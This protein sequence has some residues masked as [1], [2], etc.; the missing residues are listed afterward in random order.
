LVKSQSTLCSG[1]LVEFAST[2]TY[3]SRR[4]VA[5]TWARHKISAAEQL[6]PT[7]F[8]LPLRA[9]SWRI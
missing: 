2:G 9:Y 4:R 6:P 7:S 8:L 3:P 5:S 1:P